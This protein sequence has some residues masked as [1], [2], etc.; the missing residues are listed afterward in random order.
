MA[1][2]MNPLFSTGGVRIVEKDEACGGRG[3]R[4]RSRRAGVSH[5]ANRESARRAVAVEHVDEGSVSRSRGVER[6]D[7]GDEGVHVRAGH[8]GG[9]EAR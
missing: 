6:G 4:T 5:P 3:R 1:R 9:G 7:A 2:A 8:G